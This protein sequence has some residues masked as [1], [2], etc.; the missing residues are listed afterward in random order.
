MAKTPPA[1]LALKLSVEEKECYWNIRVA[2]V[3]YSDTDGLRT[4]G[5]HDYVRVDG[6]LLDIPGA[7]LRGLEISC[8]NSDD[9]ARKGETAYGWRTE[10]RQSYSID[11]DYANQMASVLNRLTKKMQAVSD[12]LGWPESFS[13]YVLRVAKCLGIKTFVVCTRP[14]EPFRFN[15]EY[16]AIDASQAH[17]WMT[18]QERTYIEKH[19][20]PKLKA[21][22]S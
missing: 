17:Y 10:Y 5:D 1:H 20:A 18:D 21:N 15:G 3:R 11:K 2:A 16:R 14:G 8:Q 22:A 13:G 12:E 4:I 6:E 19:A 7:E 9:N